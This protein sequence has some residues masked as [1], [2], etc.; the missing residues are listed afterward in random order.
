[1]E[2]IFYFSFFY[3]IFIYFGYGICVTIINK[4]IPKNNIIK[5]AEN[6][7]PTVAILIA[8]YNEQEV[9]E[10]KINNTI[11]LDYPKEKFNI[12]IISDGSDDKT[13]KIIEKFNNVKLLW[14]P[15]RKGKSAAIN[16]AMLY[17]NEEITVFTDANVML[18]K[19]ALKEIINHYANRNIGG[20]SGEKRVIIAQGAASTEGLYW[21][22]ESFLKNQDAKL[23]TLVGAA[24]ELFS[25][26]TSLFKS[27]P[28]D[29]LLDDLMIS[30]DII[31]QGYKIAY[32]PNAYA[33]ETPSA[34]INEEYKRKVRISAGGLQSII[35]LQQFLNPFD[36]GILSFQYFIR[37]FSRWIFAPILIIATFLSNL[38][39]WNNGILFQAIFCAQI[40]FH[41]SALLGWIVE[42]YNIKSKVFYIPFYFNF[43]HYCIVAGWV[44]FISG[45][46]KATWQKASR[47]ATSLKTN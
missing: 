41:L 35:R 27:I 30:M 18:N 4:I 12:Y 10:Q 29:T 3:L 22:Y 46:Q 11:G 40:I 33:S 31:A 20:V 15:V 19:V 17:I 2:T 34:N 39:L 21:K 32:E 8:A 1:M 13:N 44:K 9:I 43:M 5:I 45:K 23:N 42:N 36:F 16:R 37:R 7:L 24:G 14:Q 26:R 28:E 6:E 38:F 25:I 47:M